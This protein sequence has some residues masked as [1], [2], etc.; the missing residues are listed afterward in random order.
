MGKAYLKLGQSDKAHQWL[1]KTA[2]HSPKQQ[3]DINVIK[4]VHTSSY[5]VIGIF[6]NC[7]RLKRRQ[8]SYSRNY[9]SNSYN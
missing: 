6:A 5:I 3:E 2:D 8:R 4:F 1:Q 7:N 9:N